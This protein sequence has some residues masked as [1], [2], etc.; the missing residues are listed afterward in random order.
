MCVVAAAAQD[1]VDETAV[2]TAA[3]GVA[4]DF[5]RSCSLRWC[6]RRFSV[7]LKVDSSDDFQWI[8]Y[9]CSCVVVAVAHDTADET[10][11]GDGC[12]WCSRWFSVEL[13]VDY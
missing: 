9:M 5:Q 12:R 7:E 8:Q 1:T 11:V 10:A 3:G 13:Q 2:V 4:D 6:S